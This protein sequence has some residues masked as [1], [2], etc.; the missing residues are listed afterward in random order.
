MVRHAQIRGKCYDTATSNVRSGLPMEKDVL[1][2]QNRQIRELQI[3]TS[4]PLGFALQYTVT[5]FAALGLAFYTAWNLTLV[6]IALIPF[7]AV[8]LAWVSARMQPAINLQI[9][10]LTQAS[11]LA[12]NA[13]SAIDTVKS[14]NGQD[15]ELWQYLDATKKAAL[16]YL[17]QA[18]ANA[19]QIGL[20]RVTLL[21]IFVQGFWYGSHLV[22]VGSRTPGQVL[23]AFWAC[24]MATQTMEQLLPQMIVLEK[25]RVAAATLK[26]VLIKV[27]KGRKI[28]QMMGRKTPRYCD[29][30]IQVK[31]VSTFC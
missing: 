25:G 27:D 18:R 9:E 8:A 26:A 29:G 5:L 14:F 30:D 3:A 6:T 7:T 11:K 22:D 28:K 2:L 24:L 4:Q 19:L 13:I 16:C 23:T 10:H 20:V 1:T 15:F 31:R 17:L 12:N 21:G